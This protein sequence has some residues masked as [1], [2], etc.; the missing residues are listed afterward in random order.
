MTYEVQLGNVLSTAKESVSNEERETFAENSDSLSLPVASVKNKTTLG[1]NEKTAAA[2]SQNDS[3][4]YW[5][6]ICEN[7]DAISFRC[8]KR[9]LRTTAHGYE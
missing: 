3:K 9:R 7:C 4:A 6:L 8:K 5:Q 2:A 1:T